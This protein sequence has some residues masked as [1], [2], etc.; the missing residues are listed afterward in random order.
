MTSMTSFSKIQAM[1]DLTSN[2]DCFTSHARCY[3]SSD[4]LIYKNKIGI[5]DKFR[6]HRTS[7]VV[8]VYAEE[9]PSSLR[10]LVLMDNTIV[11]T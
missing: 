10:Y 4:M 2:R 3:A 9:Q 6:N 11:P 1:C 5:K 8:F 7:R